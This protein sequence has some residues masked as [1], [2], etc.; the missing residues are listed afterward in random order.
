MFDQTCFNLLATY[1][2]I[3]MFGHQTMFSDVWSPNISRLYR[4]LETDP[5]HFQIADIHYQTDESYF[6]IQAFIMFTEQV[7]LTDEV[8]K[9]VVTRFL[10]LNPLFSQLVIMKLRLNIRMLLVWKE[11]FDD[12]GSLSVR[13]KL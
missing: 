1:F 11:F 2:N 5:E 13:Y 4:S 6:M 8:I 12:D 7:W 3:S 10:L 9:R